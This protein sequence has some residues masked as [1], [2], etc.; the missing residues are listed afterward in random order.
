MSSVNKVI[1]IDE[2][3]CGASLTELARRFN[4]SVSAAR[5]HVAKA[6]VLRTRT[7]AVRAAAKKG[8]LGSGMRGTT[9]NFSEAHRAN[10]SAGRNAW[11]AENAV[12][13]SRKPSGYLEFTRGAHKGRL[14]HVV[15]L[16]TRLGRRLH[17]DE[18]VHHID[19]NRSNNNANNLALVTRSGHARLH[20]LQDKMT[21]KTRE[22]NEYGCFC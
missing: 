14:V 11:S 4:I 2:Y 3:R 17:H 9:R 10:I 1:L 21:G 13:V 7:E 18:T 16:E 20:R 5:Y 12:G 22:R 19:G 6:G 15:T 8:L